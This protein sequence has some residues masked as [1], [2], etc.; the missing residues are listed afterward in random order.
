MSAFAR[1]VVGTS[2]FLEIEGSCLAHQLPQG[3]EEADNALEN[4]IWRMC[5]S[6]TARSPHFPCGTC[7]SGQNMAEHEML[8]LL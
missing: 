4:W 6:Y 5:K 1:W 3:F 7:G 2:D 8:E